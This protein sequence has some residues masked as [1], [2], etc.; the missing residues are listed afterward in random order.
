MRQKARS[1]WI[2]EGDY[3][4]RYFHLLINSNRRT[5][6]VNGVFIKGSWVEEPSR[7]KEEVRRFFQHWF[8]ESMQNKP[9]LN[10]ISFNSIG[11]QA[12]QMLVGSFSEEEIRRAVWDC[13]NEKSPGPDGLNFKFI[14]QF[15]Q[16]LKPDI[17]RFLD[18][19]HAH[20]TFPRGGNASFIALI[21]KANPRRSELW[22][23]I[24]R[25]SERKLAR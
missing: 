7:V 12:N 6:A 2:K 17:F 11:Q 24:L 23:L 8:Q 15:W 18:E 16:I 3:N 19:F 9:T 4:S 13:G 22:D 21:P 25:K 5:N 14:K 20:G 10:G 1:R